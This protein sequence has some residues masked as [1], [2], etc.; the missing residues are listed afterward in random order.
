MKKTTLTLILAAVFLFTSN[1]SAQQRQGQNQRHKGPGMDAP[2]VQQ[3]VRAIHRNLD[4]SEEQK[5]EIRTIMQ[6]LKFE[7]Q[8]LMEESRASK[9]ALHAE[10]MA[11]EYNEPA[12]A[13][14]AGRQ[15]ELATEKI[16]ITSRHVANILA[17]LTDDQR[18][19]LE[20]LKEEHRARRAEHR[21]RK[22]ENRNDG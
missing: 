5:A 9:K 6:N 16:M 7:M 3:L 1:V 19:E 18:A 2:V 22:P 12:V 4:L 10:V 13:A 21:D 8:P 20:A 15:G 11:D 17:Q 14:I